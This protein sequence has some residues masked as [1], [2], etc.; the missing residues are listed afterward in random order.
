MSP[1]Y[2]TA[3][4]ALAVGLA[5]L[6]GGIAWGGH[7]QSL[8]GFL[9]DNLVEDQ[10]S[11]KAALLNSIQDHFYRKV[12]NAALEEASY[13]GIVASLHDRYSQYFTPKEA[14]QFA[15]SLNGQFE[16]V[17]MSVDSRDTKKGL[18]VARVFDGSPAKKAGITPGDLIVAVN[19][20]SILGQSAD[21]TTAK[22]RGPAGTKVTLKIRSGGKGKPRDVPLERQKLDVPLVDAK[23]K[24]RGGDKFAV[25]RLAEFD[26]G[27]HGQVRDALDKLIKKGAKGVVLDL[28]ANPGGA[29][30][31]GVLVASEFLPKDELV[32]STR[33]RTETERK[34]NAVG[35]PIDPKL[36]VVV[37]VDK[38][39][40]SASEIVTG[41]L[42]DHG[43]ATIVG[44]KTFG[45]GVFQEIDPLPNHGLVKLTVGGYY[46]PKG[47]NLQHDGV[48]PA[49]KATDNPKTRRDEA[50]PA[51]L[52]T[53]ESKLK[54]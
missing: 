50:L 23:L 46:L 31:E 17:G 48:D 34:F 10:V 44:Q 18:R 47:E 41:A 53:L 9:R 28:R 22:I 51:A 36:P 2:R 37:L 33:G 40:A 35:D 42:R 32:V 5:G 20:K 29:L 27:A 6:V 26:K 21:V 30:D 38:N 45:K 49:V 4:I 54:R 12:P 39:S 16:G 25:I 8:P 11:T 13:K 3:L 24:T 7:P 43:R 19:G 1:R 15:Q 52:R 14:A